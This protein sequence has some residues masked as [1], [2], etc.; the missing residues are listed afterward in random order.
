MDILQTAVHLILAH[1]IQV[2]RIN[3]NLPEQHSQALVSQ[4]ILF[5][6]RIKIISD[7]HLLSGHGQDSR[8]I[9]IRECLMIQRIILLGVWAITDSAFILTFY[10]SRSCIEG[11]SIGFIT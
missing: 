2:F 9:I 6:C 11:I 3:E 7:F 4:I 10:R 1:R 5:V 8:I